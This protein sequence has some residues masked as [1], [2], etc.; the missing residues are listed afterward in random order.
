MIISK[1]NIIRFF[2]RVDIV[3]IKRD[4]NLELKIKPLFEYRLKTTNDNIKQFSVVLKEDH[5]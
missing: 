2:N 5:Y 3:N 1:D 4:E